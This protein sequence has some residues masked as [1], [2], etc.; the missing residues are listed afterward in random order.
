MN[1]LFVPNWNNILGWH[2]QVKTEDPLICCSELEQCLGIN[3]RPHI[4]RRKLS[5]KLKGAGC[6]KSR[7]QRTSGST[8]HEGCNALG[9]YVFCGSFERRDGHA[10][11]AMVGH[12]ATFQ[13]KARVWSSGWLRLF[14]LSMVSV[15][16]MAEHTMEAVVFFNCRR[17]SC[18][19]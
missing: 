18:Q 12:G 2:N 16:S 4:A 7:S 5:L 15:D 13:R 3:P 9:I 17:L 11:T 1:R 19:Q 8:S 14:V 10:A 6:R